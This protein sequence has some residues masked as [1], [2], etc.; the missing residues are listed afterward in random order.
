MSECYHK[1]CDSIRLPYTAQF[2]DKDFYKIVVQALLNT[3]VEVSR[4]ACLNTE[5]LTNFYQ[6]FDKENTIIID[7]DD[8]NA[9]SSGSSKTSN[10]FV[11]ESM[12]TLSQFIKLFMP[13]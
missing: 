9:T 1:A 3:V 4:S 11:Q 6:H 13:F 7:D 2:A 8:N 10:G 5:H 12:L